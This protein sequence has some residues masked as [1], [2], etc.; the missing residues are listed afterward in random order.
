[1]NHFVRAT[2]CFLILVSSA[3][4]EQAKGTMLLLPVPSG[5]VM[6]P[7]AVTLIVSQADRAELIYF[8]TVVER[9]VK[10]IA[11][12]FKPTALAVQGE[13]L[14]AA[15]KGASIVYALDHRTGKQKK[16]I[17]LGGDAVS[18]L[19]CHPSK[20]LI[21]AT[22][23]TL[24]V[25]AIDPVAAT[26]TRTRATGNF[27]AVDPVEA[28]SVFTAVQ[29]PSEEEEIIIKDLPGNVIKIYWDRWGT[30]AFLLK[31][32]V[33]GHGLKLIS[34]QKNA[35]VN[36][37]S[38]A[39]TPDGKKVMMTSGGGWR[40]PVEGG[41]GGGYICAAF[42]ADNLETR[43][44]EIPTGSNLAFHPVLDLGILNQQGRD[45]TMFN[46]KSLVVGK[47]L[48][49]ATGADARAVLVTFAAKGTK[50]VLWNG[51][52]PKATQEGLHFLQIPLKDS[53]L[54][55]LKK[56][57]GALPKTAVAQPSSP[58]KP[59]PP[60]KLAGAASNKPKP[61]NN[62]ESHLSKP[63]KP[64]VVAS[65][66]TVDKPDRSSFGA[67]NLPDG[68]IA[69]A[70][71]NNSK[72]LNKQSVGDIPYPLGKSNVQG[73]VNEPGWSGVWPASPNASFVITDVAEGDGALHLLPTT[74]YGRT[75]SKPQTGEFFIET[76]VRC[77]KGGGMQCYVWDSNYTQTGPMW[78]FLN[79]KIGGLDGDGGGTGKPV[80][81]ADYEPDKWYKI[82][83]KIDTA[84]RRWRMT[85]NDQPN[86]AELGFRSKPTQLQTINFLVE[87]S[88]EIYL[89]AIR[90]LSKND[91]QK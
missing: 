21:Y 52:N 3:S 54:T 74:N 85:V 22:T 5:W 86:E 45:I 78:S 64:P 35:A 39:I 40:P 31:Y 18:N 29:P 1:M 60:A 27:I 46:S 19:A 24:E 44:G 72:G 84:R 65:N 90:V 36:A 66:A 56:V 50:V 91:A 48:N 7:D 30:R 80:P 67:S 38:L 71:F 87:G 43:V 10:R 26:A 62:P 33:Q 77:P 73:G 2:S 42:S 70:G 34:S 25:Y 8:D 53:D 12:D 15:S 89:D 47:T 9:E 32:A 88:Q 69:I 55:A 20:G 51:D 82:K 75:L 23:T 83:L 61:S 28:S 79:G 11:V 17:S 81:I 58:E 68:V 41:S 14:F 57:Y 59:T 13:T 76:Y 37:Y 6:M 16:E 49:I 63:E 4:A